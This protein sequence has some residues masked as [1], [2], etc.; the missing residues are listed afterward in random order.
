[1]N[2]T[3]L[4]RLGLAIAGVLLAARALFGPFDRPFAVHSPI[5]AEGWFAIVL[6]VLVCLRLRPADAS[7][8]VAAPQPGPFR[9]WY[10]WAGCACGIALIGA[11]FAGS[12]HDYFLADDFILLHYARDFHFDLRRVFATGGGDGFFRPVTNLLFGL[13]FQ[14]A[15]T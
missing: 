11:A 6:A 4:P 7:P 9:A 8:D 13:T 14:W 5:N 12:I 1:M 3:L 10:V 2:W 15:G